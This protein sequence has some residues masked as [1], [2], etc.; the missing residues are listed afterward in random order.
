MSTTGSLYLQSYDP[1]L[2]KFFE[3]SSGCSITLFNRLN[4]SAV[5]PNLTG[6]Q[7]SHPIAVDSIEMFPV[8]LGKQNKLYSGNNIGYL[9]SVEGLKLPG[10]QY[11]YS[12]NI[13]NL[14]NLRS[15]LS[16]FNIG[17]SNTLLNHDNSYLIG[18]A[19]YLNTDKNYFNVNTYVVGSSNN[20]KISGD[21]NYFIG[22][23]NIAI[24]K[25]NNCKLIGNNNNFS[26]GEDIKSI[27]NNNNL[28]RSSIVDSF[29]D[30]SV[31]KDSSILTSIGDNNLFNKSTGV[32]NLSNSSRVDSSSNI[33][34][35]GNNNES[36]NSQMAL[37]AGGSNTIS[38]MNETIL[39]GYTNS[40]KGSA[41]S[42]KV[43][44]INNSF[45]N[46]MSNINIFG[47]YNQSNNDFISSYIIGDS[48]LVTNVSDSFINGR[49]NNLENSSYINVLGVGNTFEAS[50]DSL[51]VGNNNTISS[52]IESNIFGNN[53]SLSGKKNY[54]IGNNNTVR[55]GDFNSIL[56]G[57]S[58]EFAGNNKIASINL[59]V[60]DNSIEVNS[61]N[62]NLT[63]VNRPTINN[64]PIALLSEATGNLKL[65]DFNTLSNTFK[66]P[67]YK[68]LSNEIYL[69]PFTYSTPGGSSEFAGAKGFATNSLFLNNFNI[70]SSSSYL[71]SGAAGTDP[72]Y[73]IY[74]NH[75]SPKFDP[76]WIIV[77]GSSDGV[78]HINSGYSAFSTPQTGWQIYNGAPASYRAQSA[79]SI[80][81]SMG[82]RTGLLSVSHLT[83]GTIYLPYFY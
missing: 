47:N 76:A 58:H 50:R 83:L 45:T 5:N 40:L 68:N 49:L 43:I 22:S 11:Y 48:N 51:I 46:G 14:N 1:Q 25:I 8:N 57:I 80:D 38:G 9:N 16:S 39:I 63:S 35:L 44:G 70:F 21:N 61:N 77:D 18:E 10:S 59:G 7:F 17:E 33:S 62:I 42:S 55:S 64:S 3:I 72:F 6:F 32:L 12:F 53:N 29:G 71:A 4:N 60:V 79:T 27:G 67:F 23:D 36:D 54:V 41:S 65:N 28:T 24:G 34:I 74:G 37:I 19:N 15:G 13:G 73:V 31:F 81:L 78:Y 2:K 26:S 30:Y 52:G 69:R 56:I 20:F 75:T 66:D 82:S